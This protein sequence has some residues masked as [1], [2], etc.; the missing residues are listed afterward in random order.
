MKQ[1]L[2]NFKKINNKWICELS[3]AYFADLYMRTGLPLEIALDAYKKW[4]PMEKALSKLDAWKEFK[5]S[6]PPEEI[7]EISAGWQKYKKQYA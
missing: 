5:K 2:Y 7:N 1:L 6:L 3:G 4:T